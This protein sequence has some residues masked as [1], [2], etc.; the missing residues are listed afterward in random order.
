MISDQPVLLCYDGSDNAARAIDEA[1]KVLGPR[2][3]IVVTVWQPVIYAV[4]GYGA[5]SMAAPLDTR[6]IDD[7]LAARCDE[8]SAKGAE[9]AKAAG[10]DA[11]AVSAQAKTSTWEA[12]LNLADE[13]DAATIVV[14]SRGLSGLK[15]LLLGSVSQGVAHHAHRPVLIVPPA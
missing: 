7:E 5:A 1:A 10:F 6:D 2:R 4:S 13:R 12:L 8:T 11:E 15:S 9:R 14:G 3:A